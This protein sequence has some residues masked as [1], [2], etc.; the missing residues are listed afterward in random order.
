MRRWEK[1]NQPFLLKLAKLWECFYHQSCPFL[2]NCKIQESPHLC[3]VSFLSLSHQWLGFF[4]FRRSPSLEAGE[5]LGWVDMGWSSCGGN[6]LGY[7]K[8][9]SLCLSDLISK[10][11]QSS[12]AGWCATPRHL[13]TQTCGYAISSPLLLVAFG[14]VWSLERF[15]QGLR[16]AHGRVSWLRWLW[17]VEMQWY[18]ATLNRLNTSLNEIV[19]RLFFAGSLPNRPNL[20]ILIL[21]T[22]EVTW[23]AQ[24]YV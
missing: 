21:L 5:E 4:A 16:E 18:T 14:Q 19:T 24:G 7:R 3:R 9:W 12:V 15:L 2:D 20:Y 10:G 23:I 22:K 1:T 6:T 17:E 11:I 8:L 13:M